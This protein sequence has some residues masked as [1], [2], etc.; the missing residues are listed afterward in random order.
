MVGQVAFFLCELPGPTSNFTA[1][2]LL[3]VAIG[4][5]TG[6]TAISS[7]IVDCYPLQSMSVIT[8]YS[9]FLDLSALID[10]VCDSRSACSEQENEPS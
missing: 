7:Y 9:V 10:P 6:N 8:F 1:D 2:L 4:L 5:Q 3:S